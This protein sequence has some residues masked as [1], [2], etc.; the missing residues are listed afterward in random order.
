MQHPG[1]PA[2]CHPDISPIPALGDTGAERG[3]AI[4]LLGLM[5]AL[6]SLAAI[7]TTLL[8]LHLDWMDRLSAANPLSAA[9]LLVVCG[10]AAAAAVP[11]VFWPHPRENTPS[12]WGPA[13]LSAAPGWVL[14]P[15]AVLFYSQGSVWAEWIAPLVAATLAFGLS[16][17]IPCRARAAEPQR[18]HALFADVFWSDPWDWKPLALAVCIYAAAFALGGQSLAA[19]SGLLALTAFSLVRCYRRGAD[20]TVPQTWHVPFSRLAAAAVLAILLA[21]AVLAP[22]IADLSARETRAAASGAAKVPPADAASLAPSTRGSAWSVI[23]LWPVPP[24]RHIAQVTVPDF[25]VSSA[26]L[27]RPLVIRFQGPYWYFE[28]RRGQLG[29]QSHVAHGSP[30]AV[31]IRTNDGLPLVMEVH[32]RLSPSISLANCH[33]IDISIFD[34]DRRPGQVSLGIVLTDSNMP[35]EPS[36][37]LGSDPVS[38]APNDSSPL[39][40][41]G[42]R[43]VLAFQVPVRAK[44]RRFN[45]MTVLFL[46]SAGRRTLGSK[47]AIEQFELFSR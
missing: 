18:D 47:I 15:P 5:A 7:V 1:D 6:G 45:E 33:E 44:I 30:T 10:L 43:E 19:A 40:A 23:E 34:A 16:E 22:R 14:I 9:L 28:A 11:W 25:P 42:S 13:A 46:P 39:P 36:V 20:A 29:L 35:G 3:S 37:Y 8:L 38:S 2:F 32:Q 4:R 26:K 21:A 41:S 17:T 31:D 12:N 24:K 27:N